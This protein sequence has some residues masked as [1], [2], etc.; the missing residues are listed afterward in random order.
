MLSGR[1][2][3]CLSI[4]LSVTLVYCGQMVGWIKM[5]LGTEV[6]LGS[7]DFVLDGDPA[8]I[9]T[10]GGRAPPIFGSFL[11]W[12]NG[13]MH[14]DATWYGGSPR[15]RRHCVRW[16]PGQL[17]RKKGH[18]PPPNFWPILAHVYCGQTAGWMKTPLGTE[19]YLWPR[20][21]FV[22]DGNSAAPAKGAQQ[23]PLFG[24][25]LMWPRTPISATAEHL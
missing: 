11:L 16:G 7:G 14:Q 1:C 3:S 24:P 18:S 13:W 9:P 8:P 5:P 21:H 22:S 20:P 15:P 12:P 10:K 25:C 17:P 23:P 4:C 2:L 6:G 19:V